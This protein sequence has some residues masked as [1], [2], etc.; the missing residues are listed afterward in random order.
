MIYGI[1][2]DN[3]ELSRIKL[4]IERSESF[5]AKVLV[6][7]EWTRYQQLSSQKRRIEFLAV[8]W[9][10]K[11]AYVKA[12]GTGYAQGLSTRDMEVARN[13]LGQ[14]Y[15]IKHPF[16]GKAS[17]SLTHSNLEAIAI[18]ILEKAEK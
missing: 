11:E 12:Y 3:V 4:A 10:A 16:D 7:N 17:L 9:A 6:G 13:A 2:V 18:V 15:F 5:A 1:G 14:P 8:R